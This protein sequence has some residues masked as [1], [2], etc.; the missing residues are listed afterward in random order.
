MERQ[1][2]FG[3]HHSEY[4]NAYGLRA[5]INRCGVLAGPGQ[6]GKVDQG[7]FTLW[8]ANHYFKKPLKYTGFGGKGKQVRDLLHPHD[9]FALVVKQ[10]PQMGKFSG[11]VFNVGGGYKVSTSLVEL[12]SLCEQVVGN[13]TVIEEEAE[14]SMVDMPLY[15]SDHSKASDSFDWIPE[16]SLSLI[17][18]DITRWIRENHEQ[19]KHIFA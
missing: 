9:L 3:T 11:Q 8:V 16:R 14:S 2:W 5:I 1:S 12:T 4:V 6:F 18:E 17:V 7:V 10:L 15:I 19:L 13:K